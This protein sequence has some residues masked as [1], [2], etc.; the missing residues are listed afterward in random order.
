MPG[1]EE[2]LSRAQEPSSDG[3]SFIE[4]VRK[5]RKVLHGVDFFN[6][7]RME[8]VELLVEALKKRVVPRGHMII[9]Q[10][11]KNGDAFYMISTG[12]CTVWVKQKT[13]MVKVADLGPDQYFGERALVTD[14]PRAAT[15]RAELPTEL[16]VLYKKDFD[17]I[18]MSNPSISQEIQFTV[19]Q[20]KRK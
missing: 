9:T 11:E 10:G 19:A 14:E 2:L 12:R 18:L 3:N 16:Y 5:L 13:A 8:E 7:L 15:V 17:A 4:Q 20:Y 6:R 1:P